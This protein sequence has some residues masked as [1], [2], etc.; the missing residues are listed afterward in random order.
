MGGRSTYTDSS[1]WWP[2]KRSPTDKPIQTETEAI[3]TAPIVTSIEID[4]PQDVVFAHVTDPTRFAEW[5]AG[6]EGGS[7]EGGT[8]RQ[9]V[10]P[11]T[12]R[13]CRSAPATSP[14]T[15]PT[16]PGELG[17]GEDVAQRTT[18]RPLRSHF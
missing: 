2:R 4:R 8:S 18:G 17:R 5:Q 15:S 7:T 1:T 12:A 13:G 16:T 11:M 9:A 14:L 3:C 6:V 10:L